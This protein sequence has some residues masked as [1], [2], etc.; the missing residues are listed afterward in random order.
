MVCYFG[1]LYSS[2]AYLLPF[3]GRKPVEDPPRPSSS[4]RPALKPFQ[5]PDIHTARRKALLSAYGATS[6]TCWVY[7]RLSLSW[8]A[9]SGFVFD[10]ITKDER[11]YIWEDLLTTILSIQIV[12]TNE[13]ERQPSL[14][15]SY[16]LWPWSLCATKFIK[17]FLQAFDRCLLVCSIMKFWA[18]SL[19]SS[20]NV[21]RGVFSFTQTSLGRDGTKG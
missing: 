2:A 16:K 1:T 10:R 18:V 4:C 13:E 14:C 3:H 5:F 19:L 6:T 9:N 11:V 12:A 7:V 20:V 17:T 8:V 21:V 15:S